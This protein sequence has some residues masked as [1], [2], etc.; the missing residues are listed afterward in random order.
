MNTDK[1]QNELPGKGD[2]ILWRY[3]SDGVDGY[4]AYN[5]SV[6][7]EIRGRMIALKAL[8][9]SADPVWIHRDEIEI[10]WRGIP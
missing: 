4:R 2:T 6:V 10:G 3:C 9:T 7:V 5:E 8:G 1:Y